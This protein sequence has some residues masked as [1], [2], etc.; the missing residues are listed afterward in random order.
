AAAWEQ[1]CELAEAEVAQLNKRL[2]LSQ[3][4]LNEAQEALARASDVSICRDDPELQAQVATL[5]CDKQ[6]LQQELTS[7]T[8]NRDALEQQLQ[9]EQHALHDLN[10]QIEEARCDLASYCNQ[11]K[12]LKDENTDLTEEV[13]MY[14][15]MEKDP[16]TKGNSLFAEVVDQRHFLEQQYN[17]LRSYY[18]LVSKQYRLKARQVAQL[19]LQVASLLALTGS[20]EDSEYV[21][22]LNASL[23]TARSQ[24]FTLQ[25]QITEM[26]RR[27]KTQQE[28][29]VVINCQPG[30]CATRSTFY[31]RTFDANQKD[32]SDTKA[33]L[34]EQRFNAVLLGE[35][36]LGMQRRLNASERCLAESKAEC[37]RLTVQLQDV[38]AE[39]GIF[40]DYDQFETRTEILPGHADYKE[41]PAAKTES[42]SASKPDE[43]DSRHVKSENSAGKDN[44]VASTPV[45]SDT[46]VSLPKKCAESSYKTSDTLASDSKTHS[47]SASKSSLE[48]ISSCFS[49]PSAKSCTVD[50]K[51]SPS[52][53]VDSNATVSQGVGS[54]STC[55]STITVLDGLSLE[56]ADSCPVS[57]SDHCLNDASTKRKE[58]PEQETMREKRL[59]TEDNVFQGASEGKLEKTPVAVP[60]CLVSSS[61]GNRRPKKSVRMQDTVDIMLCDDGKCE[62]STRGEM[63]QHDGSGEKV[64][65][66]PK[67]M[68]PPPPK[69]TLPEMPADCKQQ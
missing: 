2:M 37:I 69:T 1:Q 39:K 25:N 24:I 51:P 5:T 68:V 29:P 10:N 20:R 46:P 52:S 22:H 32:L 34:Q 41:T 67:R 31:Q 26:T 4:Q 53:P 9:R 36:I 48:P 21:T 15:C 14:K 17:K 13:E 33:Q 35:Q 16:K 61:D 38:H 56:S 45:T 50:K 44:E 6:Q 19:K 62:R 12:R 63:K 60:P 65:R 23:R 40:T 11:V 7:V 58:N 66:I 3:Q 55:N 43:S 49:G 64:R 27:I 18:E 57:Q 8:A 47:L 30:G 28:S 42:G 59:S 54:A